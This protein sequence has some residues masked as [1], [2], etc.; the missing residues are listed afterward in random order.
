MN[1][2]GFTLI[3]LLAVIVILAII[4]LIATPIVLSIINQSKESSQLRSAEMYL[5]GVETSVA[6]AIIH[7]KS[8][9]DG[10]HP[11]TPTGDVCLGTLQGS[12]ETATCNGEE[13]KVEMNG[14]KPESG[15]VT[16]ANG[17]VTDLTFTYSNGK[18]IVKNDGKLAFAGETGDTSGT[19][20]KTIDTICTHD[21]SNGVAAKTAG[22]K[23]SCEVKDGT[24]YNFYVLTTPEDGAETINLIMD[25]NICEDGTPTEEGKTCIV[26][27]LS[28][29]DYKNND[30]SNTEQFTDGGSCQY[31]NICS[32]NELGPITAMTY[33]NKATSTWKNIDN[34]DITYDDEGE[35][36]ADFELNGK[37]RLPYKSEISSYDS[38]NKTNAYL[39]DYLN[40]SGTIQTNAISGIYGYWTLSSFDW[41]SK[42]ALRVHYVGILGDNDVDADN[43]CGV[44]PVINLKI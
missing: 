22:A 8:V 23:Y 20:E 19:D 27:W 1:K 2:R 11:I 41:D 3:E 5:K 6:S 9:T 38:T 30:G 17:K 33:L 12:G 26:K 18:T 24:S 42:Y 4:A 31:G 35:H 7:E 14:E 15:S 16:I 10:E 21:T 39:Y 37:A 40:Q 29:D 36:F 32:M 34:L 44:R 25:R 13:L 28:K 43:C